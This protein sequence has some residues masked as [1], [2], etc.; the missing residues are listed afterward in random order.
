MWK[1]LDG[2]TV[3]TVSPKMYV[4]DFEGHRHKLYETSMGTKY[5]INWNGKLKKRSSERVVSEETLKKLEQAAK[6]RRTA[7]RV[8]RK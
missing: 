8:K 7:L 2:K 3:K 1:V 5:Y 4:I 6:A